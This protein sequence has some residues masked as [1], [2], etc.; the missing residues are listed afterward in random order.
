MASDLKSE[1]RY[2]LDNKADFLAKYRDRFVVIKDHK[3]IGVFDDRLIAINET[4][5]SHDMGTFLVQLVTEKD[6]QVRVKV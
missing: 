2:Y 1:F 6:E 3:V 4:R 5:K